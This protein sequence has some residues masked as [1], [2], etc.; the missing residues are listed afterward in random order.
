MKYKVP[1]KNY[2]LLELYETV[3]RQMGHEDTS[4]LEF[5]CRK[6]NVANN[7]QN[8]FYAHYTDLAKQENPSVSETD[9]RVEITIMLAIG[10]PKVDYK[11]KPNEIEVFDGFIVIE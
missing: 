6:I 3:A 4:K 10:G 7:I 9:A 11:L 2:S 5:D 1:N 8:G